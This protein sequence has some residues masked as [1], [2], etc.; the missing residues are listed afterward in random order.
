MSH[1]VFFLCFL[2][3]TT[4]LVSLAQ[5]QSTPKDDCDPTKCNPGCTYL[6]SCDATQCDNECRNKCCS[7]GQCE[8]VK[9]QNMCCCTK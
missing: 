4:L 1:K 2:L 3:A 8:M 9:Y 6:N 7:H 5:D